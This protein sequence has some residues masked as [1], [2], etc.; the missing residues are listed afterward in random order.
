MFG[1][2]DRT[3]YRA[4][5][6]KNIDGEAFSRV[7]TR[8]EAV[9]LEFEGWD[10]SPA[11]AHPDPAMRANPEYRELVD[12]VGTDRIRM[13]NLP[14]IKKKEILSETA[15]RWLGIRLNP[16]HNLRS[17]KKRMVQRAMSLGV[18]EDSDGNC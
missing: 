1:A 10:L 6:Y 18:W 17:M 3:E 5:I 14:A 13:L 2:K 16:K 9:D 7:V 12:M 8:E 4:L 15:K 11:S